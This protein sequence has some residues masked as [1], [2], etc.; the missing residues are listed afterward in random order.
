MLLLGELSKRLEKHG[1]AGGQLKALAALHAQIEEE[2][3][4]G[5]Y[6]NRLCA[7][8]PTEP[9]DPSGWTRRSDGQ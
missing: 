8:L 2:S 1:S 5:T 6:V 7:A 4:Q 3:S 9:V